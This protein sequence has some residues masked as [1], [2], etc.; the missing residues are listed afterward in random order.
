MKL[1]IFFLFA[2]AM[3][4]AAYGTDPAELGDDAGGFVILAKTGISTV[5]S[6][7]ITGNIAASPITLAAITS[8]SLIIYSSKTFSTSK[9][10]AD[11]YTVKASDVSDSSEL[12]TAISQMETAYDDAA[13]CDNTVTANSNLGGQ[14]LESGVYTFD[15]GVTIN[16]DVT[17][18]GSATDVFIIQTSG[19]VIQA[20]A[21]SVILAGDAKAENIFWSVAG[22]VTIG[23]GSHSEGIFLVKKGVTFLT[24]SNLNGRIFSQMAVALQ[25]ATI[26]QPPSTQACRGLRG[27]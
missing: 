9:Q 21:T 5:P 14:T 20:A 12:I 16:S 10:V 19:D 22:L 27:L 26:T 11:T 3:V 1:N 17:F 7:V 8:F 23:A 15:V 13:S 4:N 25:M 2:A 18:S 6:S 24:G